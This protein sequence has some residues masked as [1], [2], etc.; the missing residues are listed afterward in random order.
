MYNDIVTF[1]RQLYGTDEFIP[2]HAP[3]FIGN[4]KKYL[5]EC[6]DS[7]FVSSVGKFVDRFE[8]MVAEYTGAKRAVVC[9]SG[10]NALHMAMLLVGVERSD[11]VLTQALTF[12]ATCNAISYIGAHPVF[13]DVDKETL[14]LSPDAVSTWLTKNAV[15]KD[16]QCYNIHTGRR[17]KACVPM[18]TF[19]HPVRIKELAAICNDW[20]IELVED[21]AE[22]IGSFYEGQHTGTFGKV[23]VISF[24][25]NKTITT[26]GGG[27]LLF[28][29]EELGK[30]AKHLTTQAKVP[31]R[32]EFVHDHV[33]YNYRMPNINAA[34][35]CAQMENLE[36]YVE[37]KRETAERYKEFFR[38]I[39]GITFFTEPE[40][41]RSNYWLNVVLLKDRQAQQKF[42]EYTNDH[43]V[44]TR[45]AWQLM[46]KLEMFRDCEIDG[47]ENTLWLEERIVNIPSSV[48][49]IKNNEL[50]K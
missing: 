9:V 37:N 33:G 50:V 3:L 19:G 10:T 17:V 21:A 46:N 25:G 13:I 26:G 43:G 24:N 7:T 41:C 47:L 1:I 38:S 48:I 44:M 32:W 36:R 8:E 18:H 22:S 14:G 16:G 15:I 39:P 2:L 23:G 40:N 45:P 29:D 35:G 42:L 34:I 6:I 5:D 4:E 30:F 27:M 20:Y 31:H 12:I 11:E 28:R 49:K